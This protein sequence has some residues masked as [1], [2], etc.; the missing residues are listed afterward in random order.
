VRVAV[1]G[2]PQHAYLH[3]EARLPRRVN[4]R[5]LLSPF[6]SLVWERDRNERPFDFHYRI[7]IYTPEPKRVF[8]YYVLPFL[9]G[10]RLA[11]RVDLKADRQA[12]TLL[13][14]TAHLEAGASEA[15]TAAGLTAELYEM[16]AWL[17][18]G[19]VEVA[20]KGDLSPALR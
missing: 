19:R 6:D 15:V 4:A 2:W 11:A 5:A 3:P 20:P 18:L 14:Q 1:E 13:V 9:L 12:S 10:D 7:D 17:G 8:G 16:A